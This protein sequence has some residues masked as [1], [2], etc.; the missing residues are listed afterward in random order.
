MKTPATIEYGHGIT[1]IDTFHQ[2]A[3]LACCYLMVERGRCALIDTGTRNSVEMIERVM[4]DKGLRPEDMDFIIPTHVHLDHAGGAGELMRRMPK[5]RLV[6]HPRGARHMIDPSRLR[7]GAVAVYGEEIF[8]RDY[9]QLT[10]IA[11]ERV[12][13]APDGHRESLAGRTLTFLD[14]PGHANHHFCVWD[15]RS[16]GFFTGDTFGL[17]YRAF[18]T[19][20]GAFVMP[21]TTPVQFNP[22]AWRHSL[23]RM[24][25]YEPQ[26]MFLT[27]FGQ[28]TDVRRMAE[29]LRAGIDAMVEIARKNDRDGLEHRTQA[30]AA[31]VRAYFMDG[32]DKHGVLLGGKDRL[33]LLAM[34]I[35]LNA[36]GLDVWLDRRKT[37]S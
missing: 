6:V 1:C 10:P 37:G 30:I 25:A 2:R 35:E 22:E 23:D 34:D 36:M 26:R 33:A 18:D 20:Q 28:V 19:D 21:T 9:G 16:R 24:M 3:G 17:S 7:A 11:A 8:K 12:I 15:Q 4:A 13:E 14:T 27:H 29:D 5:A 32:L 31:D